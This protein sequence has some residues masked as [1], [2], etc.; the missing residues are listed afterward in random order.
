ML[1]IILL[2]GVL[3]VSASAA[4]VTSPTSPAQFSMSQPIGQNGD[5]VDQQGIP[6][7]P[8]QQAQ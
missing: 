4:S 6:L 5:W 1:A 3:I 2:G 7:V 8:N